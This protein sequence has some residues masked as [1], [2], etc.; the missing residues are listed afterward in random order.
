MKLLC[1][2][3]SSLGKRRARRVRDPQVIKHAGDLAAL[4]IYIG[5]GRSRGRPGR[6]R[7]L[8]RSMVVRRQIQE[9]FAPP[10]KSSGKGRL[11]VAGGGVAG[12]LVLAR[13][14]R[15]RRARSG[16]RPIE[17]AGD[18]SIQEPELSEARA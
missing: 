9:A 12:G 17:S 18:A 3:S 4:A 11:M 8:T 1:T 15:K 13:V 7:R 16:D 5:L 2:R 6:M 10:K 14:W